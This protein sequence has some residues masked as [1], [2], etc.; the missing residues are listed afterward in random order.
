MKAPPNLSD[1][2]KEII[3]DCAEKRTTIYETHKTVIQFCG[4]SGYTI[5]QVG[6]YLR[7][8]KR[9]IIRQRTVKPPLYP[10]TNKLPYVPNYLPLP[11]STL[12]KNPSPP[13]E[14]SELAYVSESVF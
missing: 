2:A 12:S 4:K 14:Q 11:P 13:N 8:V 1:F 7:Y 6:K 5:E 9:A 3:R 10:P